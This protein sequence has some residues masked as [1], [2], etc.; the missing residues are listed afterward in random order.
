MK[1]LSFDVQICSHVPSDK[2]QDVKL[3][4]VKEWE[5]LTK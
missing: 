5:K 2:I 1:S 3:T 4:V